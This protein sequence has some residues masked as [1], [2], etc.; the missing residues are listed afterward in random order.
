MVLLTRENPVRS[1]LL[2]LIQ[3]SLYCRNIWLK[4][5]LVSNKLVIPVSKWGY[6]FQSF[7]KIVGKGHCVSSFFKERV[8][9]LPYMVILYTLKLKL[10]K[11]INESRSILMALCFWKFF[12]FFKYTYFFL[13]VSLLSSHYSQRKCK[14]CHILWRWGGNCWGDV[15]QILKEVVHPSFAGVPEGLSAAGQRRRTAGFGAPG[16]SVSKLYPSIHKTFP[17]EKL[18]R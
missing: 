1:F 12:F 5:L 9:S 2:I 3:K 10:N 16:S 7:K 11:T 14:F 18:A 13:K 4:T 8:N 15:E 17:A 6:L